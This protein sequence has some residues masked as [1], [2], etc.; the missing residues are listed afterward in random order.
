[1]ALL[2]YTTFVRISILMLLLCFFFS[3]MIAILILIF[4]SDFVAKS[5]ARGTTFWWNSIACISG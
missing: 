4:E 5:M 3:S 1:M 2:N